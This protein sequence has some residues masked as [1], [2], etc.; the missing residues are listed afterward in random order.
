MPYISAVTTFTTTCIV[1]IKSLLVWKTSKSYFHRSSFDLLLLAVFQKN[2][3]L[4]YCVATRGQV[5]CSG[6][7]ALNLCALWK[8]Q[9]Y[10][11]VTV[12]RWTTYQ[13]SQW[14][15]SEMLSSESG[16]PEGQSLVRYGKGKETLRGMFIVLGNWCLCNALVKVSCGA[17]KRRKYDPAS[18]LR[19]WDQRA[20]SQK[21]ETGQ[22]K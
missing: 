22:E 10:P 12:W 2:R 11:L 9:M 14:I 17:Q 8:L 19:E 7:I 18:A 3:F 15:I 20:E 1:T 21:R 6:F 13:H 16:T 5:R 4:T